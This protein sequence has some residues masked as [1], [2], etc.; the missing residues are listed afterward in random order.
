MSFEKKSFTAASLTPGQ[1]YEVTA[2]FMDYDGFIHPVGERWRFLSK[3]FLP[4][5]DGLTLIVEKEGQREWIRLQWRAE[6]QDKIID[7]FSNYVSEV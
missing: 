1:T 2:A 4:Y 7:E 6:A 5:E 3:N